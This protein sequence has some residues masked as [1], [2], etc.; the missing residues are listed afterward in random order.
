MI[1]PVRTLEDVVN[2]LDDV[3]GW[4]IAHRSRIGY[5]AAIYKKTELEILAAADVG[6]FKEPELVKQLGVVFGNRYFRFVNNYILG[7]PVPPPW[8]IAFGGSQDQRLSVV[9]QVLL[10]VNA[11]VCYDLCPA[12][13]ETRLMPEFHDDFDRIN[14]VAYP[15]YPHY[16]DAVTAAVPLLGF[17]R[18]F[19][20]RE[21]LIGHVTFSTFR[22]VAWRF[23]QA[24]IA[25]PRRAGQI[26]FT[27]RAWAT[28]L[29][30]CY[31]PPLLTPLLSPL[32]RRFESGDVVST[33]RALAP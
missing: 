26:A 18:R 5:F 24:Q 13:V 3:L 22:E 33:I 16:Y 17:A 8:R 14:A 20:P 25:S 6:T 19:V 10:N 21:A 32:V 15:T 12:L 23:A 27:Q 28:S 4:S 7:D 2:G 31:R 30:L 11:H 29:A 1:G 9:Q